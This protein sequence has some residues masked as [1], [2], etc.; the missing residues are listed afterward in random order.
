MGGALSGIK[1]LD[2]GQYIAGPFAAQLLAEQGADVIKVERPE[3]D[4]YRH[5]DGF[6]VW[7]RSKKAI[8]LDLKKPEGL[9]IALDLAK[10]SDIIIENFKPGM[11]DKMGLGYEA[12]K[13][14]NP[15]IIYCS[16][17]GFG[18]RGSYSNI[19]GYDQLVSALGSVYTEQGFPTHPLYLVLPLASLYSAVA[20]ALDVTAGLCVREQT[21]KGQKIDIS[22]FRVI[23][24]TFRQFLVDFEGMFRAPWGPTGPMPLYRPYQCKDGKWLFTGLGNPKF[25]TLFALT[26]G[27]EEWLTD[28]LFEGAPFLI[29]PPRNAQV[30]AI[31]K[32]IYLTKTRD[33]W[34]E[35]L[36]ENEIPVATV[37]S[38][39]EFMEEPQ[40][41][42]NDMV[43]T[44]KQPG[45]GM[46]REMGIPV[47]FMETPGKIKGPAPLPGQHTKEILRTLGYRAAQIKDLKKAGVVR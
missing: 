24:G 22:M 46:V 44:L 12:V 26:L 47:E 40:V 45:V 42:A 10:Q 30:M 35:L 13:A 39:G 15:R 4:P 33:E 20:A 3:G 43:K 27:H 38:V 21:G 6:M 34:I 1:I 41:I 23:L 19:A 7:N 2:F 17:S 29:F 18:P 37:Q 28:P 36:R 31:I 16:I 32:D 14:T 5:V 25:F 8:T 9:K 11:M